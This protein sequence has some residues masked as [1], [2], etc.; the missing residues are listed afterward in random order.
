[1]TD[2][3]W[4]HALTFMEDYRTSGNGYNIEELYSF[5][6]ETGILERHKQ[7]LLQPYTNKKIDVKIMY[8]ELIKMLLEHDRRHYPEAYEQSK[9][10]HKIQGFQDLT[11]R[12]QKRLNKKYDGHFSS[13][14]VKINNIEQIFGGEDRDITGFN[15]MEK[16]DQLERQ[17]T[18]LTEAL[19]HTNELSLKRSSEIAALQEGLMVANSQLQEIHGNT[20]KNTS[21]ITLIFNE[22][23]SR[24]ETD[25]SSTILREE[26]A[27]IQ[28]K[29]FEIFEKRLDTN[30]EHVELLKVKDSQQ[31]QIIYEK[32]EVLEKADEFLRESHTQLTKKSQAVEEEQKNQEKHLSEY[33]S[34][35]K[36]FEETTEMD[37]QKMKNTLE[38]LAE[39]L[40]NTG[41]FDTLK[42]ELD[43]TKNLLNNVLEQ[44]PIEKISILEKK[45][46]DEIPIDIK[47]IQDKMNADYENMEKQAQSFAEVMTKQINENEDKTSTLIVEIKNDL[48]EN[49]KKNTDDVLKNLEPEVKRHAEKLDELSA[50]HGKVNADFIRMAEDRIVPLEGKFEVMSSKVA[51]DGDKFQQNIL[52]TINEIEKN[53]ALF[54]TRF[55]DVGDR[56]DSDQNR[57]DQMGAEIEDIKNGCNDILSQMGEAQVHSDDIETK[58]KQSNDR[59]ETMLDEMKKQEA[60]LKENFGDNLSI[61]FNNLEEQINATNAL[62]KIETNLNQIHADTLKGI[63]PKVNDMYENLFP[64]VH[65]QLDAIEPKTNELFGKVGEQEA[66]FGNFNDEQDMQNKRLDKLET[67]SNEAVTKLSDVNKAIDVGV[68]LMENNSQRIDDIEL[69]TKENLKPKLHGLEEQQ[70]QQ[71]EKVHYVE[72]LQDKVNLLDEQ[73]QRSDAFVKESLEE[74]V[75]SNRESHDRLKEALI[76]KMNELDDNDKSHYQKISELFNHNDALKNLLNDALREQADRD[77]NTFKDLEN[78][79]ENVG[80]QAGRTETLINE[81][82]NPELNN[83]ASKLANLENESSNVRNS[84]TLIVNEGLDGARNDIQE[85]IDTMEKKANDNDQ[86]IINLREL[87]SK[88]VEQMKEQLN[89]EVRKQTLMITELKE[90]AISQILELRETLKDVKKDDLRLIKE[91]VSCVEGIILKIDTIEKDTSQKIEK[92]ERDFGESEGKLISVERESRDYATFSRENVNTFRADYEDNKNN[93]WGLLTKIFGALRG[94]TVIL[95]SEGPALEHQ[96]DCF[97]VYRMSDTFNNRPLYKQDMGENYI[98]YHGSLNAWMIGTRIGHNHAWMRNY[99]QD[100]LTPDLANG[101]EYLSTLDRSWEINDKTLRIEPLKDIEKIN[102]IIQEIRI[103]KEVD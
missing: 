58:L 69:D 14:N 3:L 30:E 59:L 74:T 54:L 41:V 71:V 11:N 67:Y 100:T 34:D 46:Y 57:F 42:E 99:A 31:D 90:D 33:V 21:D 86:H 60:S 56:L 43:N 16:F 63:D 35:F 4:Y 5:S 62:L 98:Y 37:Q 96:P 102:E 94:C 83:H 2:A 32:F 25:S 92:L 80:D 47:N 22:L 24:D 76:Q 53:I 50:L 103:A 77:G 10:L 13:L 1:M 19:E 97:G 20:S 6:D 15:F 29:T 66:K 17:N 36:G 7:M 27:V 91:K 73:K 64:A 39:S 101:W 55:Q 52:P 88:L 79:I 78:R 8:F 81:V 93:I 95:K 49:S 48:L 87:N 45:V 44:Q 75:K 12:L 61:Q 68:Q 65:K 26:H 18:L 23:R 28:Q 72:M 51:D 38:E 70:I 9:D 85:K 82:M 84:I 89:E 40:K